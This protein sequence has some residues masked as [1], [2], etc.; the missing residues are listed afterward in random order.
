MFRVSVLYPT[1]PNS[2]F[3][4]DDYL[5]RHTP[6]VE[7]LLRPAL[8]GV[9]IDRGIAGFVP[10]SPAPFHI[11]CHLL[12]DSAQAF[13]AAFAPHAAQIQADIATYTDVVPVIWMSE[14]L[15]EA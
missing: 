13:S 14:V 7:S 15:R 9:Q 12:F 10:G 3:D 5:Q 4:L 2:R 8:R 1:A 6:M 11:A